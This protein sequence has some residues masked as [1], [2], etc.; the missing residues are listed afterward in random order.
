[1]AILS[2]DEKL[3]M[4]KVT[5]PDERELRSVESL[6]LGDY[7]IGFERTNNILEEAMEV[8]V[9]SSRSS[10]GVAGDSMVALCNAKGDLVNAAC[11]TFL[12]AIIQPIIIKYILQNYSENP[13]IKE[14]DIWLVND[15]LY[16]G[17]HNPDVAML[18]PVFY[19]GELIAWTIA[20]SH[21]TETGA[22]EPG[23]MP[24]NATSR[25]LEGGN[26]PPIKVGENYVLREDLLEMFA[27]FGMRAPQMVVVDTKARATAAH[28]AVTRIVELADEKGVAYIIGLLRKMLIMAEE[29]ARKKIQS[30]P[31]G[32]YTSVNFSDGVGLEV[33]LTRS[34]H[35]VLN[36]KGDRLMMD[37]T[38]TSPENPYS[39]NAHVQAIVGHISNFMYGYVFHDLPISSAT[40]QTIDFYFPEGSV[41]NPDVKAATSCS[42][43][44]ATGVMSAM[45]NCFGKMMFST[46]HWQDVV[47][48]QGNAGNG[49]ILAGLSQWNMPFADL[50]AYSLN[51]EGQGGRPEL[52]GENAFGFPWCQYGRAPDIEEMEN[53]LPM[54][55]PLSNHWKDSC[56]HGKYRGGSGTVQI[57]VAHHAPMIFFMSIADNSKIQTP[58]PLFGGYAP[59][60]VPGISVKNANIMEL[61]KDKDSQLTLDLVEILEEK[62]ISGDWTNEFFGR[63]IRP[64]NEGDII[65]FAFSAGGAGYGDPLDRDPELVIKDLRSQIISD[66][67]ADKVYHV[68]YNQESLKLDKE[69][70]EQARAKERQN[71]I[72]RGKSFD[73]FCE[74]WSKEQIDEKNLRFY[75]TWPDAQVIEPIMRA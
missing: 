54:L 23:G 31:D 24:I 4:I 43:M 64:F 18:M 16:G 12:H 19:K 37:F 73:V 69:K 30:W 2:P 61:M 74:D 25:F 36:K 15:A 7:E 65:T 10:M 6:Q 56:G 38:G 1:M 26:F 5:P 35:M 42:V 63:S 59:S 40:F 27:A 53:D 49:Q 22:S 32:S 62:S 13:G 58:Q 44:I 50:L 47:A 75:G 11:G 60:T 33:G 48:S 17:I 28:R 21:T 46:K 45:H 71:R 34:S 9:R 72:G 67:S 14:G 3:A 66:W 20:C 41:L 70:T 8:F 52:D 55:I 68:V 51:T 39:Y 57:W 29:G